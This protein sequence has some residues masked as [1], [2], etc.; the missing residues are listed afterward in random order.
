MNFSLLNPHPGEGLIYY[1]NLEKKLNNFKII[2][3]DVNIHNWIKA[4]KLL[5]SCNCTTAIEAHLLGTPSINYIPYKDV[6]TEFKLSKL[7]SINLRRNLIYQILLKAKNICNS[8]LKRKS[9]KEILY[10]LENFHDKDGSDEIL[11]YLQNVDINYKNYENKYSN[12]IFKI[13][14]I[15][16]KLDIIHS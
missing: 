4:S 1:K 5:I 16:K 6:R 9:L 15:L 12:F 8:K 10:H 13:F 2:T 7:M 3:E 14:L 11:S